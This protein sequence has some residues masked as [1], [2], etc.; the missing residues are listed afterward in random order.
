MP[1]IL[2]HEVLW[3]IVLSVTHKTGSKLGWKRHAS[4]F[5]A[6]FGLSSI[7]LLSKFGLSYAKSQSIA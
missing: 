1:A 3:S 6:A 4:L 2:G 7:V 5:Q